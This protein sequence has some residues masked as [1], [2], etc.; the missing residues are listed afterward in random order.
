MARDTVISPFL[1]TAFL[2]QLTD[3]LKTDPEKIEFHGIELDHIFY[4]DDMVIFTNSFDSLQRKLNLVHALCCRLGLSIN[5]NKSFFTVF[6]PRKVRG[7]KT[8][9][10]EKEEIRYDN[11]PRYLGVFL[12]E[13][14]GFNDHIKYRT[15][16]SDK[17]LAVCIAFQRSH[18]TIRFSHFW[19]LYTRMVQPV[20][21]Y[22]IEIFGWEHTQKIEQA[23]S[24]HLKRFFLLP[25]NI[26]YYAICWALGV[27][28]ISFEIWTKCY[29]FWM[30]CILLGKHRYE[31]VSL[32]SSTYLYLNGH[33]SWFSSMTTVFKKIGF[34][35]DFERWDYVETSRQ[36]DRF[37][38]TLKEYLVS[39]MRRFLLESKY[40]FLITVF[41]DFGSR[42]FLEYCTYFQSKTI[43][44]ILLSVHRFEIETG[45]YD[46]TDRKLRFCTYCSNI[47]IHVLGDETHHLVECPQH[48]IARHSCCDT[49]SIT[50][51]QIFDS[52]SCRIYLDVS[53]Y[54]RFSALSKFFF[55]VMRTTK[56]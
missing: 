1:G 51:A 6:S 45:R 15:L 25:S 37:K 27:L 22:G 3:L 34:D 43:L 11:N 46:K 56:G 35:G 19:S 39:D 41:P 30:Q 16:K 38:T 26:S 52:L 13:R 2:E 54:Y 14:L 53:L 9:M 24:A 7:R 32:V 49:L 21:L 40:S 17:A 48:S 10:L 47:A 8:L 29:S 55:E 4:A 5:P 36:Y 28:P 50:P 18:P 31:K 12:S 20:L 33:K 23:F 44:K 42:L